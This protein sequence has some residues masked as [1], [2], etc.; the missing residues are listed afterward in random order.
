MPDLDVASTAGGDAAASAGADSMAADLDSIDT[1]TD[2]EESTDTS[3]APVADE[4]EP[5]AEDAPVEDEPA[6]E[7]VEE[8]APAE[9]AAKDE[10]GVDLPEGV[11]VREKAN[12]KKEWVFNENRGRNIYEAYK[13]AQGAEEVF[14]EPLTTELAQSRQN[15]FVD[16]ESMIADY[17]SGEP[18]AEGRFLNQLANW[19]QA[20]QENGD[21]RH[22]P[23]HSIASKLPQFLAEQGGTEAF[24]ALAAPVIRM[25]LD[26]LYQEALG[27]DQKD[28]FASIQHLD[29]R[30][31]GTFRKRA[32]IAAPDPFARREAELNAREAKLKQGDSQRSQASH[33]E[34]HA[35]TLTG[36]K[37]AVED[38]ITEKLGPEVIKSYEKFPVDLAAVKTL[39]RQELHERLKNDAA[40][41]KELKSANNRAANASPE[42]RE[43]IR[44]G[45][46]ARYRAKASFWTDPVRNPK[47]A[48]ILRQRSAVIK[49]NS[50]AKHQRLQNGAQRRE[51]G[52]IGTPAKR[53]VAAA[54]NGRS[55]AEDW[56]NA[57]DSL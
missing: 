44:E 54:P 50:D 37:T 22:N 55:T 19:A 41:Q 32:D 14:G 16:Q 7:Q 40:W 28:L 43:Q 21:V 23:L 25:Q 26:A 30:L 18:Q 52:T 3:D 29:K 48:E 47:V 5:A 53:S 11:T 1:E 8:E 27:E 56:A 31:Y 24:E 34:W 51:P 57:I 17:L 6:E 13:A 36:I 35:K 33:Q 12:G 2:V 9:V 10:E 20:A 38:A 39:L 46:T 15:A 42:I 49:Q 45:L 4:P